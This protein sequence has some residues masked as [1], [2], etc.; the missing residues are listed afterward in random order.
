MLGVI[1]IHKPL[2]HGKVIVNGRGPT[3]K[4]KGVN[5]PNCLLSENLLQ[6]QHKNSKPFRV[7]TLKY[8]SYITTVVYK[9][10]YANYC[11][12]PPLK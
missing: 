2:H 10:Q 3:R 1:G 12:Q 5:F 8:Y 11:I 7:S 4:E 6:R 9:Q